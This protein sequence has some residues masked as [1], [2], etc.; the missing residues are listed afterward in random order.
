MGWFCRPD[1]LGRGHRNPDASGADPIVNLDYFDSIKYANLWDEH[2]HRLAG[3]GHAPFWES[4]GEFNS[5]LERFLAHVESGRAS[6]Q[7]GT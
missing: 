7:S 5:P 3:L 2:C 4:P 1:S 6:A